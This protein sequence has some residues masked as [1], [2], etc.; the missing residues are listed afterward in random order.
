MGS[1]CQRGEITCSTLQKSNHATTTAAAAG[2]KCSPTPNP[3]PS[4]PHPQKGLKSY[5]LSA[6]HS[7]NSS[8]FSLENPNPPLACTKGWVR[9]KLVQIV[10]LMTSIVVRTLGSIGTSSPPYRH[11]ELTSWTEHRKHMQGA[12]NEFCHG[13]G[14]RLP[15]F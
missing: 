6:L 14:W 10:D 8:S 5:V 15:Y 13:R 3:H 9:F 12:E 2:F 1:K 11:Q 4:T 7:I